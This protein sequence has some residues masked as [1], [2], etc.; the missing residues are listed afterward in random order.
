MFFLF[1]FVLFLLIYLEIKK[2]IIINYLLDW[3]IIDAEQSTILRLSN[4]V[5]K[6]NYVKTWAI[7]YIADSEILY[8][9]NIFCQNNDVF[10]KLYSN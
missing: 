3:E 9:E 1:I 10:S 4:L 6:N 7:L 5:I 2:K 8:F